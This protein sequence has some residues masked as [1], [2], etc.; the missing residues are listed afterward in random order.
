MVR[1]LFTE[2]ARVSAEMSAPRGVSG[3]SRGVGPPA[4]RGVRGGR[5]LVASALARSQD[6]AP[7]VRADSGVPWWASCWC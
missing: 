2:R 7:C 1:I 4:A 6:S 5:P 3:G